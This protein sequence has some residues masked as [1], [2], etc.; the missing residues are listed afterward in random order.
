VPSSLKDMD[1]GQLRFCPDAGNR[2]AERDHVHD[3][4]DDDEP[5]AT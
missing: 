5:D 4:G 1:E 2:R 3:E